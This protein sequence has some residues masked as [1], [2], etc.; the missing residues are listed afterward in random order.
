VAA[1]PSRA[2]N[3]TQRKRQSPNAHPQRK[4]ASKKGGAKVRA[5]RQGKGTKRPSRQALAGELAQELLKL[6]PLLREVGTALLDRLD[7]ELAG[8]TLAL[9]GERRHGEA[10][11]L[12]SGPVL[13]AMLRDVKALKMKPKKGR[14]KDLRRIEILLESLGARMP[15]GA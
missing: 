3:G 12:P 6:R 1:P 10:P 15:P 5:G 7:G 8:L 9:D 13:S 2:K 14:V 4:A 11:G